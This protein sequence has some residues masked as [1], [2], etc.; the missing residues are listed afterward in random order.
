MANPRTIARLEAQI[1]RRAAHCLQFEVSDPRATFITLTGVELSKDLANAKV[2]YSVLG[3]ETERSKA[4]HMLESAT[5]FIQR[6]V[7]SILSTR[8][9]P[10]LRF[11]YDASLE[12]AAR[13]D[14][15]IREA[16]DRDREINP[17]GDGS[18]DASA[19]PQ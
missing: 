5:G 2:S 6:Q 18:P 9:T 19:G 16:R 1:L 8:V 12:E 13:L 11:V 10:R 7:A 14:L 3:D 15:L 17:D 4:E